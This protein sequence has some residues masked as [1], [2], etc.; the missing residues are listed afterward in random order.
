MLLKIQDRR[1]CGGWDSEAGFLE[2][3]GG[4]KKKKTFQDEKDVRV[5]T[6]RTHPVGAQDL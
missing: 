6:Y 4:E 1:G 3:A 2:K 5:K